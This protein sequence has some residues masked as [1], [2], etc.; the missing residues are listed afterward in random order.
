MILAAISLMIGTL[1]SLFRFYSNG[2]DISMTSDALAVTGM[3]IVG[4]VVFESRL[5][6]WTDGFVDCNGAASGVLVVFSRRQRIRESKLRDRIVFILILSL[7]LHNRE[8]DGE[9]ED[10]RRRDDAKQLFKNVLFSPHCQRRK[11][12]AEKLSWRR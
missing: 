1:V 10:A 4:L 5:T 7:R 9:Q 11:Q 6:S 12:R 2:C 8:C 3:V